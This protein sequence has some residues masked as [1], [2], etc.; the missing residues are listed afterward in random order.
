MNEPM[1]FTQLF[2]EPMRFKQIGNFFR[3]P[4]AVA[5]VDI[6]CYVLF[7]GII[8]KTIFPSLFFL[9]WINHYFHYAF[10]FGLPI[11]AVLLLNR[12][13]PDGK[14]IQLYLWDILVYFFEIKSLHLKVYQ[15]NQVNNQ[16]V[17]GSV[18]FVR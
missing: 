4:F 2:S 5:G 17:K 15:G 7:W 3:L 14:K 1:N 11:L 10:E 12:V 6:A 9:D 16:E 13:K 18:R 8:R